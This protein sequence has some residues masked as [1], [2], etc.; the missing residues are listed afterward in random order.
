MSISNVAFNDPVA[1]FFKAVETARQRNTTAFEK[2]Q[3]MAEFKATQRTQPQKTITPMSVPKQYERKAMG[4]NT[5]VPAQN[6]QSVKT[7]ILGN[8]FDAY[9]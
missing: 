7:R 5:A 9:A 4:V 6:P 2:I 1:N 8:Y 3:P